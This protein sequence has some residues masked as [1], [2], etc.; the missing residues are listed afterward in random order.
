MKIL[1]LQD[2]FPPE[3]YGGAAAIASNLARQFKRDGHDVF[4]VTTSRDREKQGQSEYEG[5]PVFRIVTSYDLR[6]QAYVSLWNPRATREVQRLLR[7]FKPD[8]V[9]VHNVHGYL[10]YRTLTLAHK[11]G[12]R[13]VLTAHDVMSFN[14]SKLTEYIDPTNLAIPHDFNYR[15]HPLRQL[16]EQRLRYNPFR[17]FLIRRIL[18]R[19]V[20]KIIAVSDALKIALNDNGIGNVEVIH[21][22]I[23]VDEWKESA[24]SIEQFK[25]EHNIGKSAVLFGGRLSGVKGTSK[26]VEA[27]ALVRERIP[28]AQLLVIGKKDS[29][30]DNMLNY[31][32]RLGISDAII[33]TGWVSGANLHAAYHTASIVAVPTLSFDSFPTMNLEAFAC[34][35]PVVATC[36]G[37]SREIVEDGVSGYIVNPFDTK[38]LADQ[39]D[40][41]LSNHQKVHAMGRAGYERV[42]IDFS[43]SSQAKQY[44]SLFAMLLQ[45]GAR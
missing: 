8:I 45:S 3:G 31:A 20:N 42:T 17:N 40:V 24:E 32:Q 36:F 27:V 14:Y 11:S 26:I 35:K 21:N 18:A 16:R 6:F 12:A 30:A 37:G 33:F 15:I 43:L 9:H 19:D 29:A 25:R 1:I 34:A 7:E 38:M 10:S 13:V 39:I 2:D 23:D 22:G 4:V 5:I 41:L 44:E 28:A